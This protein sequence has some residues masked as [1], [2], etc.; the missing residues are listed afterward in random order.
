MNPKVILFFFVSL[1]T[2]SAIVFLS[3][4]VK[5][6][7]NQVVF[8]N[9]KNDNVTVHKEPGIVWVGLGAVQVYRKTGD[10][11]LADIDFRDN[12][13]R[14]NHFRCSVTYDLPVG[15]S[16]LIALHRSFGSVSAMENKLVRG[17]VTAFLVAQKLRDTTSGS[18]T[19]PA[20]GDQVIVTDPYGVDIRNI[21]LSSQ[22]TVNIR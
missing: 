11:E 14:V 13:G 1:F 8:I 15:D 3:Y 2:F 6:E 9:D 12:Q 7:D 22:V 21:F 10:V 4:F 17:A 19:L 18:T 16:Q 5:V 20:I